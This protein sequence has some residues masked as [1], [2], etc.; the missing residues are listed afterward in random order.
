MSAPPPKSS[1]ARLVFKALGYVLVAASALAQLA[2]AAGFHHCEHGD[3]GSEG[4]TLIGAMLLGAFVV[5]PGALVALVFLA[6]ALYRRRFLEAAFNAIVALSPVA[7]LAWGY[8][9]SN[10]PQYT[11]HLAPAPPA[12]IAPASPGPRAV[13]NPQP[14][15]R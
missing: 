10:P 11:P 4:S 8:T 14:S 3:C 5:A 7:L 1:V 9:L 13:P 2:I 15:T 6:L 12:T